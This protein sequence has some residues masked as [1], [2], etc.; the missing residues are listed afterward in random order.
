[1]Q[2]ELRIMITLFE[3]RINKAEEEYKNKCGE[4]FNK[5]KMQKYVN[6]KLKKERRTLIQMNLL[7]SVVAVNQM[8][9]FKY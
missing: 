5:E 2:N 6:R 3:D 1:M 9:R 8:K 7:P 4:D